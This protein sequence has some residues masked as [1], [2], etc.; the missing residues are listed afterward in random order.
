ME[1]KFK[2]AISFTVIG[3][4][5][6]ARN[7]AWFVAEKAGADYSGYSGWAVD[8]DAFEVISVQPW[9]AEAPESDEE[10]LWRA[11]DQWCTEDP[12]S[13]VIDLH[14]AVEALIAYRKRASD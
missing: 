2:V 11:I 12:P 7:I 14:Q 9:Q 10:A 1:D 13:A 4:E 8:A 5:E 6:Y 3:D